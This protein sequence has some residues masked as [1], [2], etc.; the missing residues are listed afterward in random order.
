MTT[1]SILTL[2]VLIP[3]LA[4]QPI[5]TQIQAD[6]APPEICE[7]LEVPTVVMAH[8]QPGGSVWNGGINYDPW[9]LYIGPP[10]VTTPLIDC[11]AYV[12]TFLTDG[13]T[14]V[15]EL[16]MESRMFDGV[17]FRLSGW[18]RWNP[19]S[20]VF[21]RQS[22]FCRNTKWGDRIQ[23]KVNGGP[24]HGSQSEN[25]FFPRMICNEGEF[26]EDGT[27]YDP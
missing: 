2:T 3:L 16:V 10:S 27:P 11:G 8:P 12:Q 7:G 9:K 24:P 1:S 25:Y 14:G 6:P 17:E 22:W 19:S 18:A 26:N 5:E 21:D 4:A 20:W 13:N 23:F 15:R